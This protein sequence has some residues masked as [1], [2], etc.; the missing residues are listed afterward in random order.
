VQPD[1]NGYY[2]TGQHT[3]APLTAPNYYD[4]APTMKNRSSPS[5][6]DRS[7]AWPVTLPD[8]NILANGAWYGGSPYLGPE[9][10]QRR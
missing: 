2:T 5:P 10:T 9:A 6:S 1:A 8:P 3:T 4:G 7:A